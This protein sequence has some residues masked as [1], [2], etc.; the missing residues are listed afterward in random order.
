[1]KDSLIGVD[2][3]KRNHQS[4]QV[5]WAL[6]YTI[7]KI[8][9][10]SQD[11]SRY[12]NQDLNKQKWYGGDKCPRPMFVHDLN[13]VHSHQLDRVLGASWLPYKFSAIIFPFIKDSGVARLLCLLGLSESLPGHTELLVDQHCNASYMNIII[14]YT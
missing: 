10:F 2:I 13:V 4:T 1:M 6:Y 5:L 12:S 3:S 9:A 14:I 11:G 7:V 8:A